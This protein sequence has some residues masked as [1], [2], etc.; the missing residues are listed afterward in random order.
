MSEAPE[1]V[2]SKGD[3]ARLIN[4]SP[5]RVSQMIT[6]GKIGPEA[7]EGEGRRARIRVD[8]ARR[9]IGER[10]DLGQRF[11]N[12][13]DTQLNAQLELRPADPGSAAVV[14]RTVVPAPPSDPMADAIKRER[15][16]GL[17]M[18]NERLAEDRLAEQ[19]RYVRADQTQAA[20]TRLAGSILTIFEGGLADIAS[21]IAAELG[22]PQR[23][24][25]HKMRA[26]FRNIRAKAAEAARRDLVDMP[27]LL[28]DEIADVTDPAAGEA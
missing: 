26:E 11:G 20:M 6:E 16:R 8:V 1:A 24:V 21:A 27:V 25:L 13:L 4:V 19:G 22:V 17:Q 18:A 28:V 2:V 14:T 3:F 23:D 5:G 9:Q 12:G 10:T 15:L 7:I